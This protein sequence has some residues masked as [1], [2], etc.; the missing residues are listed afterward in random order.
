MPNMCGYQ[1]TE[2]NKILLTHRETIEVVPSIFPSF[3][4][5]KIQSQK[6]KN[7]IPSVVSPT[8]FEL[9]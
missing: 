7:K 3:L 9:I 6:L 5:Y 4:M 1:D 2:Q 8:L